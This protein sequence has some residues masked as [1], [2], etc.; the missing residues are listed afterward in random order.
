MLGS[1]VLGKAGH[2][3]Y[4][5][6]M[7][8]TP[9]NGRSQAPSASVAAPS[10]HGSHMQIGFMTLLGLMLI[11]LKLGGVIAWSWLWVLAPF[12]AGFALAFAII[13]CVALAG[14][15]AGATGTFS[16]KRRRY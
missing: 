11:G 5:P 4:I 7:A 15:S 13:L 3:P 1:W 14:A 10:K 6:D 16:A 8:A 9:R 2:G 12:W